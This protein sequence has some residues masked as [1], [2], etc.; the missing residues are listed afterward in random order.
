MSTTVRP[1]RAD[2]ARNRQRILDAAQEVFAARGLD[3][4]MDDVAQHAGVGVGTLYRRFPDR[5]S[6]VEALFEERMR[7]AVDDLRAALD[8]PDA[9]QAL[10]GLLDKVCG[11]VATDRGMRQAMFSSALGQGAVARERDLLFPLLARLVARAHE[12][13]QLREGF[14][15]NDLPVLLLALGTV[16][17]FAGD[18][19]PDLWRRFLALFVEGVRARPDTP[20]D[21]VPPLD[22]AQLAQSSAAW[23]PTRR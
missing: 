14:S 16:A 20:P 3:V 12:T 6:L 5:E 17:D 19:A 13:G 7:E 1:M 2:A 15:E 9:W 4:N 21:P 10:L 23:R 8:E 18:T 22:E 11:Q